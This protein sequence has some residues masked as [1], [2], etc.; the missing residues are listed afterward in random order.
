MLTRTFAFTSWPI[1]KALTMA[2]A[3]NGDLAAKYQRLATE[4]A[5]LK[6]QIPVLKKAVIDEQTKVREMN[7][8]T[9]V[10]WS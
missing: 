2:M 8:V 7:T 6:A 10:R 5:K 4:Y 3:N 9:M 1:W